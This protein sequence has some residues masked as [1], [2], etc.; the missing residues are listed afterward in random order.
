VDTIEPPIKAR[1]GRPRAFDRNKALQNA[2]EVFWAKGYEGTSLTDLQKAM[3]DIS[4]PSFYAAFGSKEELFREAVAFHASTEGIAA[5][6]ALQDGATARESLEAMLRTAVEIFSQP[7]KPR[8]CLLVLGAVNCSQS[9]E[10][11]QDYLRA[12]RANRLKIMKQRLRRGVSEG[13]VPKHVD[14]AKIV[15]FFTAVLD[16]LA[17]EARDGAARKALMGIVDCA[18]A[19][20]PSLMA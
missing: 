16:G 1:R 7:N 12:M 5:M 14:L 18:M 6:R 17:F 13:D 11:V 19:A 8:G 2:T 20:W 15:L 4:A 3:G 10:K 9:N